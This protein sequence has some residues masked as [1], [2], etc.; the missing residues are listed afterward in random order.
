MKKSPDGTFASIGEAWK[1]LAM[2]RGASPKAISGLMHV[3]KCL[4]YEFVSICIVGLRYFVY[5]IFSGLRL[6]QYLL[7]HVLLV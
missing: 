3:V 2:M 5:E 7:A 1:K 6:G 4:I